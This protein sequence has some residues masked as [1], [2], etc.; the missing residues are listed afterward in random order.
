[1]SQGCIIGLS[2]TWWHNLHA[3]SALI[4]AYRLYRRERQERRGGEE[5][6]YTR[7]CLDCIELGNGD[8]K[9]ECL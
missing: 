2:E 3:W 6:L 1:M 8:E 9:V 5:V 7:E 4:N